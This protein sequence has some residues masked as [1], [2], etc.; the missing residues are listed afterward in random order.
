MKGQID[1]GNPMLI[2][3][4]W[5]GTPINHAVVLIGYDTNGGAQNLVISDPGNGS[6]YTVSYAD[7]MDQNKGARLSNPN[8]LGYY[9]SS[10]T[11]LWYQRVYN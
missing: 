9:L 4:N 6:A 7:F 1:S 11:T 2:S 5:I 10:T 8:H 3:L